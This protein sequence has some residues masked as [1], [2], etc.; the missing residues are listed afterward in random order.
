MEVQNN[1]YR[2]LVLEAYAKTKSND[3]K[4]KINGYKSLIKISKEKKWIM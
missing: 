1:D 4:D 2:S 3:I